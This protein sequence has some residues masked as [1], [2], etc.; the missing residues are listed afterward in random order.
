MIGRDSKGRFLKGR[1][2]SKEPIEERIKKSISLHESWKSRPDYI[3]DIK[4]KVPRIYNTWRGLM[5]TDKGKKQGISDSWKSFRNFY[6]D[7]IITYEPGKLFRRLD[8]TKPYSQ[9]N[10][11]WVTKDEAKLLISNL[12]ILEYEGKQLSLKEWA[13]EV[14]IPFNAIKKKIL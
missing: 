11:M 2:I 5:F 12:I 6:N 4:N 9:D 1:D 10:F 7:V 3:G 8:T 14:N 13:E